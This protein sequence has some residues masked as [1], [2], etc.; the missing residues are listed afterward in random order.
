MKKL[1][2]T[3]FVFTVAFFVSNA[4]TIN[5]FQ[6]GLSM[7]Q[8]D[9]ADDDEDDFLDY[10]SGAASTG[11]Y[12]GYKYLSPLQTDNLF[13]TLSAGIM[14]NDL[15]SYIKDDLEDS[16]DDYYDDYKLPKYINVPLSA[17][18]QY[19]KLISETMKIY[20]EG[21]AGI[22]VFKITDLYESED[23][24]ERTLKFSPSLKLCYKI[25]GGVVIQ[26]KYTISLVYMNLGAHKVEYEEEYHY[27]GEREKDDD[28]FKRELPVSSVNL[29]FGLRF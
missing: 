26:D 5:E 25:G 20:G 8:G 12:A 13:W 19:E 17:G 22:N 1:V 10:G 28:R 24:Y 21:G 11:I 15:Q 29:T 2:F 9:F 14:Y 23:D 6:V 16:Y 3:L 18:L 27:D 4:Q 7:P